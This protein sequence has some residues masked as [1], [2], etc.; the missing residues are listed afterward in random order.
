MGLQ[1]HAI[2][3]SFVGFVTALGIV[4]VIHSA[5]T[6]HRTPFFLWALSSVEDPRGV[7]IQ[8]VSLITR[9][10]L[11]SVTAGACHWFQKK[12]YRTLHRK[13]VIDYKRKSMQKINPKAA[14]THT[15]NPRDRRGEKCT[16]RPGAMQKTNAENASWR[17]TGAKNKQHYTTFIS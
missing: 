2:F 8:E 3:I 12:I 15:L 6:L 17:T 7:R 9:E 16:F 5:K 14:P 4:S 13:R 10:E 1:R 11:S